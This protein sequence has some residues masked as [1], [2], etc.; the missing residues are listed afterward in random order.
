MTPEEILN[1]WKHEAPKGATHFL[2]IETSDNIGWFVGKD[3]YMAVREHAILDY[4]YEGVGLDYLKGEGESKGRKQRFIP[5]KPV[6]LE[7]K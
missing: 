1:K 7:N 2:V 6:S 5:L 3:F 4:R